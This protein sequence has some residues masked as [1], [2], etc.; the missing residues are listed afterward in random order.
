MAFIPHRDNDSLW[1][2]A[3]I[4]I[5]ANAFGRGCHGWFSL[6]LSELVVLKMSLDYY[7]ISNLF[8]ILVICTYTTNTKITASEIKHTKGT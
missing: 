5:I 8:S 2:T 6:V 4:E 3:K 1:P 7:E